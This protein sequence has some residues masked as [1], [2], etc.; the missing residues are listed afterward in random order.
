MS[1]DIFYTPP[2]VVSYCLARL[3]V[4]HGV[5]SP[6]RVLDAGAGMG[7]WGQV[8]RE[9]HDAVRLTGV[10]YRIV[11]PPPVW[12][13]TWITGDFKTCRLPNDGEY[14]LVMGN[15]PFNQAEAFVRRAWSATVQ[16]GYVSFL[17]RLA[18]LE[19][20]HRGKNF[21]PKYPPK[22]VDVL[23]NRPSFTGGGTDMAAYA[24]FTWQKGYEGQATIDWLDWKR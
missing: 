18:F 17:L 1:L 24:L 5:G 9:L 22:H 15:P 6:D 8:M 14:N 19:G 11:E 21:W 3:L 7:A 13:G 16:G 4:G 12:Y 20:G 2:Q 10:E 23:V